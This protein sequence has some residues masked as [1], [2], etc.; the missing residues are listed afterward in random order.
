MPGTSPSSIM[1]STSDIELLGLD[2]DRP[3]LTGEMVSWGGKRSSRGA[4]GKRLWVRDIADSFRP[5]NTESMRNSVDASTAWPGTRFYNLKSASLD[6]ASP[7]LAT[8]LKGRHL[9]MIAFGGSIGTLS[10]FCLPQPSDCAQP[11]P[12][13]SCFLLA[14]DSY[15]SRCWI[16]CRFRPRTF[17]R[18]TGFASHGRRRCRHHVA[19]HVRG[20]E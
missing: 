16:V 4:L 9:Q 5:I 15:S 11:P 6:A 12:P 17:D 8:K 13:L 14:L 7:H 3:P 19:V 18:R 1:K 20:D 10:E 2:E